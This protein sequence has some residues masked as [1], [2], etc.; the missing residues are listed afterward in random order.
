M[1]GPLGRLVYHL[2]RAYFLPQGTISQIIPPIEKLIAD[3]W[4]EITKYLSIRDILNLSEVSAQFYGDIFSMDWIYI[5]RRDFGHNS[6]GRTIN[7]YFIAH[8]LELLNNPVFMFG[9]YI[10]LCRKNIHAIIPNWYVPDHCVI[11]MKFNKIKYIPND[12]MPV[13]RAL[14]LNSN[15]IEK[16][17][18]NWNP[19]IYIINLEH[20]LIKNLDNIYLTN[21]NNLNLSHN[22]IESIPDSFSIRCFKLEIDNNRISNIHPQCNIH[23]EYFSLRCN[24][25]KNIPIDWNPH[26]E[27]LDLVHTKIRK[28]PSNWKPP[29]KI[30]GVN[31]DVHVEEFRKNNPHI[32]IHMWVPIK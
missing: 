30:I 21:I 14:C 1:L 25:I 28:L 17:P 19:Y 24:P 20:N 11:L 13:L 9:L 23:A 3:N 6:M 10:D 18:T 27:Y 2:W 15:C 5:I 29:I 32:K 31:S 12:W 4:I 22:Q 7:E 26:V 16:L 8:Q